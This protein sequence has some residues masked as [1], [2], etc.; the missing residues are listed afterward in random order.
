MTDKSVKLNQ[1]EHQL[2][3]ELVLIIETRQKHV[4]ININ[5]GV[6]L[7][8]W[9]VGSKV[10]D[11]VLN[12]QRAEYGKQIVVTLSRQLQLKY[13]NNFEEKNFRRMLQFA[14]EFQDFV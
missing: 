6:V 9:Q 11:F 7:M 3:T 14:D 13:G 12:N 1:K 8:F 2:F 5:S 4:A 10:N